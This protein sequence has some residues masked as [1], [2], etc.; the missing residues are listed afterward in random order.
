[1]PS[2]NELQASPCNIAT[3]RDTNAEVVATATAPTGNTVRAAVA[4][5]GLLITSS[6]V[7]AAAVEATLTDGTTTMKINVP[8]TV[9]PH[10]IVVMFPNGH[11]FVAAAGQAV[12]LTVPAL[13]AS[14]IC[15]ASL[16]WRYVNPL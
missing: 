9:F 10:G 1:M 8:A 4:I 14:V 6:A 13:G 11:P 16:F 5:F 12:T 3:D 7:P 15:N 2:Q